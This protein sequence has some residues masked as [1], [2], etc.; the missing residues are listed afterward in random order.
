VASLALDAVHKYVQLINARRYDD[1]GDL[2]AED[3]EFLAPTGDTLRGRKT[4]QAFYAAGLRKISPDEVWVHS[5]VAEG[6]RCVIE[7]AARLA[8]DPPDKTHIVV[9]HF[10]VDGAGLV[11]RMAVYLRPDEVRNTRRRLDLD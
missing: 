2:F 6:D 1:I 5:S 3:A 7:I 8:D 11:A 9:D 4:I 10:T